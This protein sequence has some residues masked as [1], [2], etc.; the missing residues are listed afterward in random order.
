VEIVN[1][2]RRISQTPHLAVSILNNASFENQGWN[3]SGTQEDPYIISDLLIEGPP[4]CIYIENTNVH[5]VIRNCILA[6]AGVDTAGIWFNHVTNGIIENCTI[7]RATWGALIQLSE[8]CTIRNVTITDT[9][10][11]LHLG[12]SNNTRVEE[13]KIFSNVRGISVTNSVDCI[14]SGCRIFLNNNY[15]IFLASSTANNTVFL[16]SMGW[17]NIIVDPEI[18]LNGVDDGIDNQ[19]YNGSTSTGN[20]WTDYIG[21]GMYEVSGTANATDRYPEVLVDTAEPIIDSPLDVRYEDGETGNFIH[22]NP[23]DEFPY[24]YEIRQ[25]DTVV[26]SGT[27]RGGPISYQVDGLTLGAFNFTI[28]IQ[29]ASGNV[30]VDTV[31]VIVIMSI[32][33]GLGTERVV[34]AAAISC[35]MV[36]ITIVC[37]RKL[38]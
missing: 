18:E 31:F 1:P 12:A 13:S 16:N 5:F 15:G 24:T 23:S 32:F 25:D 27:W 34:A 30:A 6:P 17:N 2:P 8:S 22:W 38:R 7:T 9:T 26:T 3:G 14:I 21:V 29:D 19:W 4:Q 20:L 36:A 28:R 33:G 37:I 35:L 10:T 11:G